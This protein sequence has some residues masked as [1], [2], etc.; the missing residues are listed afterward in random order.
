MFTT[1]TFLHSTLDNPYFLY[2]LTTFVAGIASFFIPE[3]KDRTLEEIEGL[4]KKGRSSNN[5]GD[6]QR[7]VTEAL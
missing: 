5:N 1:P 2:G 6:V 7:R 4:S 3:T